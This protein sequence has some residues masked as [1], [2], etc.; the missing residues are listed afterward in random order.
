LRRRILTT[1][2]LAQ[3][4]HHRGEYERVVEL[5]TDSIA[6]CPPPGSAIDTI[7]GGSW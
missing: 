5:A 7:I 2:L 3:A 1:T 4:H 6:A